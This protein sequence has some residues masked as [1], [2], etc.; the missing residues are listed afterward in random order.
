MCFQIGP[1]SGTL[2]IPTITTAPSS[3]APKAKSTG[4]GGTNRPADS[5]AGAITVGSSTA[6]RVPAKLEMTYEDISTIRT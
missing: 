6:K 1:E 3:A 4:T 5:T 2:A